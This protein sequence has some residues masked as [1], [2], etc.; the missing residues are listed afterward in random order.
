[1]ERS[2]LFYAALLAWQDRLFREALFSLA[3]LPSCLW[4]L[5]NEFLIGSASLF[6]FCI[7]E[8]ALPEDAEKSSDNLLPVPLSCCVYYLVPHTLPNPLPVGPGPYLSVRGGRAVCGGS[9]AS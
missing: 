5:M 2:P 9:Q 6:L 1:M 7:E 8:M 3:F 4:S